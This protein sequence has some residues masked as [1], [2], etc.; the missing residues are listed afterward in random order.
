MFVYL[1]ARFFEK[2]L[3]SDEGVAYDYNGRGIPILN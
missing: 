3:N 1:L 2:I